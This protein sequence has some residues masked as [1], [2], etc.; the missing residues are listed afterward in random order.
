MLCSCN[1]RS[2]WLN[3]SK[4]KSSKPLMAQRIMKN[5]VAL[6]SQRYVHMLYL[7]LASRWQRGVFSLCYLGQVGANQDIVCVYTQF[8]KREKAIISPTGCRD[9][10]RAFI[11][12]IP[13]LAFICLFAVGCDLEVFS[14]PMEFQMLLVFLTI[15]CGRGSFLFFTG[16]WVTPHMRHNI[17]YVR[18]RSLYLSKTAP[19]TR[20]EHALWLGALYF[21]FDQ[22]MWGILVKK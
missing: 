19:V 12:F 13:T 16:I 22:L 11:T 9:S 15:V 1:L 21:Y 18:C 4:L 7:S 6:C 10:T 14:H 3:K 5:R 17:L 20:T 2:G 8:R